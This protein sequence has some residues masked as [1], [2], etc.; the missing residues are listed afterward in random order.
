MAGIQA[1]PFEG[2][3]RPEVCGFIPEAIASA[4]YPGDTC[5]SEFKKSSALLNK[6]YG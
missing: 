6:N 5:Y 4:Y 2:L 1:P 3:L